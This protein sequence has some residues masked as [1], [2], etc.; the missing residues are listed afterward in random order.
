MFSNVA[1]KTIL[2]FLWI[3]DGYDEP[4]DEMVASV[5]AMGFEADMAKVALKNF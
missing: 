3:E 2:P 5:V 1:D 4:S